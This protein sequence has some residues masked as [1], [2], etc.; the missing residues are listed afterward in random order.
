LLAVKFHSITNGTEQMD[1]TKTSVAC[2]LAPRWRS[3]PV[4]AIRSSLVAPRLSRRPITLVKTKRQY[5]ARM[6]ASP[7]ARK[8]QRRF[9]TKLFVTAKQNDRVAQTHQGANGST[10]FSRIHSVALS[11]SV[12]LA[13][14]RQN[15]TSWRTPL[16]WI[17]ALA[18]ADIAGIIAR[19]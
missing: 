19:I 11:M 3:S 4:T 2:G 7:R 18:R 1:A 8:V 6:L 14:T 13:P 5:C 9:H 16:R 10:S 15:L 17:R 12:L